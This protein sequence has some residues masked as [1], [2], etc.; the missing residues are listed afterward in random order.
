[1]LDKRWRAEVERGLRPVGAHLR[2]AGFTA[3]QITATGLIVSAFTAWAVATGHFGLAAAG[4]AASGLTDVLDG[5][6]AKSGGTASPRGAFLDSVAD[7]VSDALVLGG[8]AWYF[9]G[10]EPHLSVLAFA[11]AALSFLVSY[12][13][14]RAESLGLDARGG[15]MERAERMMLLGIGLLFGVLVPVLWL[16]VVLSALTVVQRVAKVWRQTGTDVE[17]VADAPRSWWLSSRPVGSDE[18]RLARWR[19]AA[20]PP[21]E[22]R[23]SRWLFTAR[24]PR[25]DR[26]ERPARWW[27]SSRPTGTG[28]RWQRLRRRTR[29]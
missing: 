18:S 17:G 2:Q 13:R 21:G 6:V 25:S 28:V 15:L 26:S 1:M 29:P 4:L 5:A 24:P 3:N 20:G 19:A 12:T 10:R 11:V 27:S 8:A 22:R 7:R 23:L 16:L 9:A 14:S